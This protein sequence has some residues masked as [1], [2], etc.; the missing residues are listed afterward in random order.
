M[1]TPAQF[2]ALIALALA[3]VIASPLAAAQTQPLSL[4]DC[5]RLAEQNQP[6]LATAEAEVQVAE[7]HAQGTPFAL[8]PH[9][10][11]GASHNQQ[12]YNYAPATGTSSH[13]GS[14]LFNGER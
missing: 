4:A 8:L 5:Y 1:K 14:V 10:T 13:R 6:D 12:T 3:V 7:A 2:A 9:L 11:F